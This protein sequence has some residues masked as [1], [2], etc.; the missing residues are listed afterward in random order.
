MESALRRARA[1]GG[2]VIVHVLTHKGHGYAHAENHDEDCFHSPRPFDPVTGEER[3]QPHGWTNVFGEE[4]VRLG[5]ERD[6]I[7]AITAAM[8]H[9]TGLAPFAAAYPDRIY[10]VASPSSMP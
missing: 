1:F 7:V 4:L 8:L 10:D 6:D 3:P 9:P 2:P 5:V